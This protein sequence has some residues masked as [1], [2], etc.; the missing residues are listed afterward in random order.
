[1]HAICPNDNEV[2]A[3]IMPPYWI[4]FG[5]KEWGPFAIRMLSDRVR[6]MCGYRNIDEEMVACGYTY[7][8]N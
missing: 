5:T 3:Y 2:T 4:L 6:E 8:L 7:G 1:M